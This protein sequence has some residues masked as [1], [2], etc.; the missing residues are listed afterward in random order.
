M[1][2]ETYHAMM[3]TFW[4]RAAIGIPLLLLVFIII[5]VRRMWLWHK[6]KTPWKPNLWKDLDDF[7]NGG[8]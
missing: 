3:E 2:L 6:G 1:D 4:Q 5:Q 8:D 7:L